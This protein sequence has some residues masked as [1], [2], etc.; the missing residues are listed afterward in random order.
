MKLC[1][2]CAED[3]QEQ[4][5]LCRYC[6]TRQDDITFTAREREALPEQPVAIFAPVAPSQEPQRERQASS[7]GST[8]AVFLFILGFIPFGVWLI[9]MTA[10]PFGIRWGDLLAGPCSYGFLPG[11]GSSSNCATGSSDFPEIMGITALLLGMSI[12]LF[13]IAISRANSSKKH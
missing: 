4:A 6:K 1:I 10:M 12:I 3:I 2:A 5:I 9:Y 7:G 11:S 13:V 8:S